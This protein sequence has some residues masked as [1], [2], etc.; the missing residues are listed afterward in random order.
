MG[1]RPLLN[2]VEYPARDISKTRLFF[3]NVFG[4][5]FTPYGE[6]YIAFSVKSAGLEGGFYQSELQSRQ[7]QGSALMVFLSDDLEGLQSQIILAG[8]EINIPTFEFPGGERFHFI[9]PSGNEFAVW[10]AI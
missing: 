1:K 3:E 9:E 8:G 10:R 7:D 6:E 2:Y 4:W 5:E